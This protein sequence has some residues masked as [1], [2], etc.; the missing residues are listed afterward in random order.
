MPKKRIKWTEDKIQFIV[1]KYTNKEMN[2]YELAD[3]F[4]CSN[5]TISRRLKEQNIQPHKFYEDLSG[6][7][8]GKLLVL[9]KSEKSDRR[10]YWDCL[11]DCGK[12]ITIKGDHLR[13]KRQLSCGCLNSKGE[14]LISQI[15][16]D[17]NIMF[18]TQYRFEDFVSEVNNIPYR[19]DFGIIE[20]NMLS[21]LIEFDGEQHYYFN[22]SESSWNSEEN[23]Y[24]TIERDLKKNKYCQTKQIPL[25]RIPYFIK[26]KITID[27]LR[28]ETSKYIVKD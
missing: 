12:E 24:K 19:F 5:D 7:R 3:Y 8:F 11:C 23:Y 27:D 28:L 16:A 10:L 21:Y 1:Q 2:T 4:G 20:N 6:Q 18:V 26:D 17:N 15:L 14:Y 13:Q 25:I 9:Q 22:N